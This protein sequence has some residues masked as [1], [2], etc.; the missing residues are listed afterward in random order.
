MM[1][2]YTAFLLAFIM[3]AC[4]LN[5]CTT[6]KATLLPRK[7]TER[8]NL[9]YSDM[10]TGPLDLSIMEQKLEE[11]TILT[12]SGGDLAAMVVLFQDM[13]KIYNEIYT[14]RYLVQLD[15]FVYLGDEDY[16]AFIDAQ[17][18]ETNALDMVYQAGRLIL[19]TKHRKAFAKWI[20]DESIVA[21]MERNVAANDTIKQLRARETE[22]IMHI[23]ASNRGDFSGIAVNVDG[24]EWT[25][26]SLNTAMDSDPGY[27]YRT[28]EEYAFIRNELIDAICR[29]SYETMMELVHVRNSIAAEYGYDDS[30]DMV[31]SAKWHRDYSYEDFLTMAGF[32]KQYLTPYYADVTAVTNALSM[33]PYDGD[34]ENLLPG[35]L[36]MNPSEVIAEPMRYMIDHDLVV[37]GGEQSY[38][39]GAFSEI[40]P[41]Y[42]EV[43]MYA[44]YTG[45]LDVFTSLYHELG[46]A[47]N[48]YWSKYSGLDINDC[49]LEIAETQSQALQL[50]YADWFGTLP[51]GDTPAEEIAALEICSRTG[52]YVMDAAYTTELE[53]LIYT[54]PDM[55][56]ETACRQEQE[57]YISYTGSELPAP[58]DWI[59]GLAGL[60]AEHEGYLLAYTVSNL[61]AF[62]LY[63]EYLTDPETALTQFDRL[64]KVDNSSTFEKFII[65]FGFECIYEESYYKELAELLNKV[66]MSVE[67]H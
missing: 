59:M 55:E 2:K 60:T 26:D 66:M 22:L 18:A 41:S 27:Q 5:G 6:S 49:Q 28:S 56:Y 52:A 43:S 51:G 50:L 67:R 33:K 46:H 62:K 15:F 44:R 53:Y 38:A 42:N 58:Y 1:K 3:L 25:M 47:A 61:C 4:L 30:F 12:Q 63:E 7:T 16:A 21:T 45:T 10:K 20:G 54:N 35:F 14:T 8:A 19:A 64:L 34:V 37:Y 24:A 39:G 9:N 48:Q 13:D 11:L 40:I 57:L 23:G 65:E 32:I 31:W 29:D 36:A 17:T